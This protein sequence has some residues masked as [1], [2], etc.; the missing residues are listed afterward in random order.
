M[1]NLTMQAEINDSLRN[2]G[3]CRFVSCN[4]VKVIV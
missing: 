1:K 2:D 3:I 4:D